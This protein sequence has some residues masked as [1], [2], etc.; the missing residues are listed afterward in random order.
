M[1]E[2]N[3]REAFSEAIRGEEYI[4][5]IFID[6]TTFEPMVI[7]AVPLTNVFGDSLGVLAAEVNL[8]FM[9]DLIEREFGTIGGERS[10]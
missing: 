3:K 2:E 10:G 6:E 8:K 7:M 9:W 5:S 1:T 4:S